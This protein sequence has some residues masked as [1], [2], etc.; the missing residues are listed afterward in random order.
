MPRKLREWYPGAT[1]H[2]MQRGVR[3]QAIFSNDEDYL[4]FLAI[5]KDAMTKFE[6]KIHAYCLM[7]N[8]YHLLLETDSKPVWFFMKHLAQNYAMYFNG[9]T[10]FKGHVFEARYKSCMVKDDTY[11]LQSS[12]YIHLN[13]VKAKMIASVEAY[14][15]SSF[16]TVIGMK[17]DGITTSRDTL[18]YFGKKN[19]VY[20][21][22]SFV[23][24]ISHKYVV[25]EDRIRRAM[26]EDELW[27]P[28]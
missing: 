4:V 5:M 16:K 24:D 26:G 22:R 14:K 18:A 17:D 1:Y 9:V 6:C 12:R 8:H 7:T 19:P 11:F 27:L 2:L 13:P 3:R 10:G 15:W 21:Y 25:D 23:D 20:H 28:W